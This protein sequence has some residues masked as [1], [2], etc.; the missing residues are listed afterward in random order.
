[1]ER[2]IT[3]IVT[4]IFFFDGRAALVASARM[5]GLDLVPR[6]ARYLDK[7]LIFP[8]LEHVQQQGVSLSPPLPLLFQSLLES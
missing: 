2:R 6:M 1:M 5:A 4:V 3:V 7:H 8:L